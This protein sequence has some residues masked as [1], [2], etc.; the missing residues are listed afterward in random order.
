MVEWYWR[1]K[2]KYLSQSQTIHHKSYMDW[3]EIYY[4][5]K[6]LVGNTYDV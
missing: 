2:A 5:Y 6:C 1:G 4:V 3:P